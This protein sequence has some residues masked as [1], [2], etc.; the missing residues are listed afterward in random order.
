MDIDS[1]IAQ[2]RE[3]F[4]AE[5]MRL[6]RQPSISNSGEGIATMAQLLADRLNHLGAVTRIFTIE[7][8]HPFLFAEIG[9]GPRTL[10][11]YNHYD[12]QPAR[13]EDGWTYPP[14]EP[15]LVD[16]RLFARGVADNKA[17]LL[18]RI[19]AVEAYLAAHQ[20]LPLRV[21]FL[22]EGEE[23][24]GSPTLPRFVQQHRELLRADGCLWE[25]G[26]KTED[27]R[28]L[29]ELGARGILYVEL[30]AQASSREVHSS[31]SN[32]VDNPAMAMVERL[33]RA[34]N[35]LTDDQGRPTFGRLREAMIAP[36]AADLALLADVPF[37]LQAIAS[38]LGVVTRNG[39]SNAEALRRLMFEPSCT[40]CGFA[41][42]HAG[43]DTKT[44][45]PNQATA[46]ID[47][48]LSSGLTPDFVEDELRA[49]LDAQGFG[50]IQVQRVIG[51]H[52]ARTAPD[53]AIVRATI[54]AVQTVYGV[55]PVVHPLMAASG[56][57]YDLCEAQGI[58]AVTFGAGHAND[59]THGADENIF[60][61]D[62]FQ[63]MRT[64][65]VLM[66]RFAEIDPA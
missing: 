2:H 18:L 52:P 45:I 21:C 42:G 54:E 10:L 15:Q 39:M 57:M 46:R 30:S 35:S 16:G 47:I 23:E 24:I 43:T 29:V 28:P 38:G 65:A 6:C 22:I 26:R 31:W 58:P 50:D 36:S 5:L 32:V 40:V 3:R 33:Q 63:A 41:V 56:P 59:R 14:F 11:V 8:S 61:E 48:R 49:H 55:P 27:G 34:I 20:Q 62:Y 13:Q 12:V 44:V 4:T 1:F 60:L 51:L 64:T 25:S 7:G 17:N 53:A 66:R 19:Q 9:S 37:D